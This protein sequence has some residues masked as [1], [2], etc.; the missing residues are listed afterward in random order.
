VRVL[1]IGCGYVGVPLGAELVRQG[2]EVFGLRRTAEASAELVEAGIAPLAGDLTD[3][4]VLSRLPGPFD[5][6]VNLASSNRGGA[7]VYREVYLEGARKIVDWLSA[8]PPMKYVYTSST[9]VYGQIDGSVVEESHVAEPVTET[10]KILVETE[11]VL[12]AAARERSFPAV[13]LRVAGIYGPGRGHLFLKFLKGEARMAADPERLINMI[14]L[15]DLVNAI[16]GALR[17]G[18]PGEIYNAADDEPVGQGD[19][20]GWLAETLGRE[21]PPVA[22]EEELKRRKRGVTNKRVSNKKLKS[23]LGVALKFPDFRAG[24]TAEIER[25]RREGALESDRR[26]GSA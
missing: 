10:G 13:T 11:N 2:H 22:S 6:V 17:E 12:I 16:I 19:F 23:E 18:R 24:Y 3:P 25:L 9:S 26:D 14:H 7:E 4:D 15:T 8:S 20:F 1:I 21:L 5:W